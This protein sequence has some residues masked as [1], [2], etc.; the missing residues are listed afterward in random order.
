MLPVFLSP[1]RCAVFLE[2]GAGAPIPPLPAC[3]R[4]VPGEGAGEGPEDARGALSRPPRSSSLDCGGTSPRRRQ[5]LLPEGPPGRCPF[6]RNRSLSSKGPFS[7]ARGPRQP[8]SRAPSSTGIN[9]QYQQHCSGSSY[10]CQIAAQTNYC[11]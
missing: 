8:G 11:E 7:K 1:L 9:R 2:R 6:F 3:S 4:F 5:Q 10:I